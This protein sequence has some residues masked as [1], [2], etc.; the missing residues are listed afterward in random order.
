MGGDQSNSIISDR[1]SVGTVYSVDLDNDDLTDDKA[2]LDIAK[3]VIASDWFKEFD[4]C[5]PL[6]ITNQIIE[7][8]YPADEVE[9]K[10]LCKRVD[11]IL[12][13]ISNP[14][15]G[16]SKITKILLGVAGLESKER[17]KIIKHAIETTSENL[18]EFEDNFYT[19]AAEK[20]DS[21]E[22]KFERFFSAIMQ[23]FIFL[24][25]FLQETDSVEKVE[26]PRNSLIESV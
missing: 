22:Y 14:Y 26:L 25:S 15:V 17:D 23:F 24:F 3:K 1:S 13:R 9:I 12:Y 2:I 21:W 5:M 11:D 10:D 20:I 7:K 16:D 4:S 18:S 6:G 19:L 8:I